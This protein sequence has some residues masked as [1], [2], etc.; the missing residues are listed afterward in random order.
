MRVTLLPSSLPTAETQANLYLTSYVINGVVAI[1]A[2]AIGIMQSPA[3]Q[4]RIRNVFISHS[5]IDHVATLPLFLDNVYQSHRD[6]VVVHGSEAV[7]ESLQRD[8]FNGRVWPDYVSMSPVDGPFL[9]LAVLKSGQAVE[10]EG[11]KI[12]P[13]AVSH[14]VPSHGFI[15]ED[16]SGTIVIASDTGP[17]EELWRRAHSAANLRAVFLEASFPDSLAELAGVT[18]H[19]TPASFA[20]E[21]GK[22]ARPVR[23]IVVHLKARWHQQIAR[24]LMKLKLPGVEIVQPGHEYEF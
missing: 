23:V 5:H 14:T 13:V 16:G 7:L 4:A 6:C 15:I 10:A 22:L 8:L 20:V 17:T 24:E 11:L 18:R 1:D 2:G 9:K 12:T 3:E 21:V 19:L